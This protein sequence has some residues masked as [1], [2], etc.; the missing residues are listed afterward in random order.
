[1]G[2]ETNPG[3]RLDSNQVQLYNKS[4]FILFGQ[5]L[6]ISRFF[7][8]GVYA[9]FWYFILYFES[10]KIILSYISEI[11]VRVIA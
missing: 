7:I 8:H 9:K 4:G 1:M 2:V 6:I 5:K 10:E 3:C 11:W